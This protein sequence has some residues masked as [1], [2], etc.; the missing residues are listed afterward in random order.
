[1]FGI[2]PAL[3]RL[4]TSGTSYS[5]GQMAPTTAVCFMLLG[6]SLL[7]FVFDRHPSLAQ[8]LATAALLVGSVAVIGYLYAV[9]GLSRVALYTP[10]AV[11]TALTFMLLAFAV[12][13]ARADVGWMASFRGRRAG[14]VMARRLMPFVIIILVVIGWL[15]LLAQRAGF[16]DTTLG[17]ALMTT[18]SVGAMGV[19]VLLTASRLNAEDSAKRKFEKSNA[20]LASIVEGT[21]DAII[22]VAPDLSITS[23]NAA[24]E[25]MYGYASDEVIGQPLSIL[26]HS[27]SQDD[28][29]STW[30]FTLAEGEV[31]HLRRSHVTKEGRR[32]DVA[33]TLSPVRN[34]CGA[35]VGMSDIVRDVTQ[36]TQM[37]EDL[38]KSTEELNAFFTTNLDLLC[39]A[40]VDGHFVKLNP[41]W[42]HV[43]G[44]PIAELEGNV[45]LDY[46]HPDD[47]D[48]TLQAIDSLSEQQDV[49]N[50]ANRYRTKDGSYRWIE[51]RSHP[52][53]DLIYAA[54][55]DITERKIAEEKLEEANRELE[56]FTYSVS[57]DLRAPLR[58]ISG[59][60]DLLK[61]TAGERIDERGQHYLAMIAESTGE[62]GT[63]I[64]DLLAFSRMGRAALSLEELNL[65]D[66]VQECIASLDDSTK[67]REIE[68]V[69]G[70]LPTVHADWAMMRQVLAN[71]LGN[72][73]KYTGPREN[74]RVEVGAYLDG[75][76]IV[77]YVR[78]NG[79][80]FD[81]AYIDKL[82]G[83]FQRL[84]N[85]TDFEGTG[86]GLANVRRI[87]TRHDGRTWAEGAV[88][89]GAT[90]YFS[91]PTG[92]TKQ[93]F[94]NHDEEGEGR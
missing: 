23:W 15:R 76:E 20:R 78:D 82:F 37:R 57:H 65:A 55:R 27:E 17:V 68:W 88:D 81:M 33:V 16:I 36:T 13:A 58:H 71:L 70:E 30:R 83:V 86:I 8:S 9:E 85:A 2:C 34:D 56:S 92:S 75:S 46:V 38:R 43:L 3:V 87:V 80:G 72:A 40:D 89:Q 51:W 11:N 25:R 22:G 93:A 52:V 67:G 28:T 53:G 4:L 79:V 6:L 90:F 60:V 14:S 1:E 18:T 47:V 29:P 62:M 77:I 31:Q 12:L 10:M 48:G 7:P 59:F 19:I 66:M 45:F 73:V 21:G 5:S 94:Q 69:V 49:V 41:E 63:L 64:D 26:L 50:F 84:H 42:E 61:Q 39:I 24:A 54:A 35:V 44:Y 74:P 91:L 32:I